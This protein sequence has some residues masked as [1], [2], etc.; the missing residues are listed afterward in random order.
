MNS[1]NSQWMT[2]LWESQQEETSKSTLAEIVAFIY[3]LGWKMKVLHSREVM[4]DLVS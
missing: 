1:N 3:S 2:G 4:E